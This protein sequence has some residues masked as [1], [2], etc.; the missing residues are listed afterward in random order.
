T[1]EL[2]RER[3]PRRD[4]CRLARPVWRVLR[5]DGRSGLRVTGRRRQLDA[6]R[7]RPPG[8]PLGRS[9]D[10]DVIRI[11]LPTH[12]RTLAG[13]PKPV[14]LDV[15]APLTQRTVLDALEACYPTLKGTM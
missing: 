5:D 8:S 6:D 15:E 4:G 12:L 3:A 1:G 9:A 7:A 2:L 13:V 14:C 11:I 10:L